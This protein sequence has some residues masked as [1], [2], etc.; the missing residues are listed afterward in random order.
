MPT[1]PHELPPAPRFHFG[2]TGY[3]MPPSLRN[4][5]SAPPDTDPHAHANA[6][7]S[8]ARAGFRVAQL[9]PDGKKPLGGW[10]TASADYEITR[11]RWIS[12]PDANVGI[13]PDPWF[14][15]FDVDARNGGSLEKLEALG[16]PVDGYREQS[17]NGRHIPILMPAGVEARHS[18]T[19]VPGIEAKA[20]GVGVVSPHSCVGGVWYRP[21]AA[22]DVWHWPVL[23]EKWEHLDRLTRNTGPTSNIR[24]VTAAD[25]HAAR[26]VLGKML[27]GTY[28]E[29]VAMIL[30]GRWQ[31]RYPSRS[32]ADQALAALATH[33]LRDHPRRTEIL[34]ALLI[35][36][37]LK[38]PDHRTPEQYI[39][40]T[41][42]KAES[43][44]SGNDQEH[45]DA[46]STVI[47]QSLAHPPDG[48][49]RKSKSVY[50]PKSLVG[51]S[52]TRSMMREIVAFAG[53]PFPDAFDTLDGWRRLPVNY[54]KMRHE[55]SPES[56]RLAQVALNQAGLIERD[57]RRYPHDGGHRTDARICLTMPGREALE[58]LRQDHPQEATP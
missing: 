36:H 39:A 41:V 20:I 42:Q 15:V 21:E 49:K 50:G 2:N 13:S 3:D 54:M 35:N 30:E 40:R 18:A 48:P 47:E 12:Y 55:V 1:M 32:E 8:F 58:Y 25:E 51:N 17:P 9:E 4:V 11:D 28:S 6:A 23:P 43:F 37:S 33:F 53:S 14:V 57:P 22:R 45:L 10:K 29:T 56:V 19:I 44:R 7:I 5:L 46:L 31:D 34:T 16:V 27:K 24:H 38:A 26:G 52:K